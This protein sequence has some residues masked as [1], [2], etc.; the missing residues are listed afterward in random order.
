MIRFEALGY[1]FGQFLLVFAATM[2]LPIVIAL[3]YADEGLQV[4]SITAASVGSLGI[5]LVRF[6]TRPLTDLNMRE[7]ILLVV[8]LWTSVILIG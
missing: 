2:L 3:A 4:F 8:L 5:L 7:G 6:A 1:I